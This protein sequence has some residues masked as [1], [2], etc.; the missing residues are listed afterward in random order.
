VLVVCSTDPKSPIWISHVCRLWR[1]VSLLNP[2]LWTTI[3]IGGRYQESYITSL[4]QRSRSRP[5]SLKYT[6]NTGTSVM[7][8]RKF[9]VGC[10]HDCQWKEVHVHVPHSWKALPKILSKSWD[11]LE[12]LVLTTYLHFQTGV[13]DLESATRLTSL[14]IF[15][16]ERELSII[17][18]FSPGLT[19]LN[20]NVR[21]P[22]KD[23]VT[24]LRMCPN[25]EECIIAL[26][27]SWASDFYIPKPPV[28]LPKMR[29]LHIRSRHVASLVETLTAPVLQDLLLQ[30]VPASGQI[31]RGT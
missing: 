25:L 24:L 28:H 19:H 20:L 18:K 7:G 29:K 12:T 6:G 22:P 21:T 2:D 27:G 10:D 3:R 16:C 4:I 31:Y 8:V 9:L 15:H 11:T 13:L 1:Q 14:S 26:F 17:F 5:V 23:V 30:N